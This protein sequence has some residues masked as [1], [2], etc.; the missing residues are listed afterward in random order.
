MKIAAGMVATQ[1]WSRMSSPAGKLSLDNS[2]PS[3]VYRCQFIDV[4][5]SR[6]NDQYHMDRGGMNTIEV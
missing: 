1:F 6:G 5:C 3:E 4:S 2:I